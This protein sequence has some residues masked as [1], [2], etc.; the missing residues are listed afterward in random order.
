ML[1]S[2]LAYQFSEY[3]IPEWNYMISELSKVF[4]LSESEKTKLYDNPT[5]KIIAAIPFVAKCINPERIAI[6][7]LGIFLMEINGFQK[8]CAH[9][10]TDDY[11]IFVRLE[12]I[13]HFQGG[14]K[15]IIDHGIALL[16]YIMLEGYKKSKVYD[17]KNNIYNPLNSYKWNYSLIKNK[18][19]KKLSLNPCPAL[20]SLFYTGPAAPSWW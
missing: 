15:K 5:A 9:L 1:N 8:Y 19:I 4:K 6:S 20:D 13:S 17:Y 10:P 12:R 2:N 16:A 11:D 18:L 14:D 7:H 3:E